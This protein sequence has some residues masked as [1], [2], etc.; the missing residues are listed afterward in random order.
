MIVNY[1]PTPT[2]EK[3]MQSDAKMRVLAGPIG[4]LAPNT[5]IVTEEGP[6]PIGSINRPVRVLS[7]NDSTDQFQLSQASAAFP[8][9]TDYLYRVLTTEG[10]FVA[11][12]HHLL[13]TSGRIWRKVEELYWD[14]NHSAPLPTLLAD[15]QD[16]V[17]TMSVLREPSPQDAPRWTGKFSGWL[18]RCAGKG[19]LYD[20]PLREVLGSD[21]LT[22]PE[23]GGAQVS[24]SRSPARNVYARRDGRLA[25][26][27]Q[28]IRLSIF[29]YL[30]SIGYFVRHVL[31]PHAISACCVSPLIG[32]HIVKTAPLS[33]RS[34]RKSFLRQLVGKFVSRFRSHPCSSTERAIISITREKV[35]SEYWDIQVADTNN[36][37]T[38]DGTVHHN[39]GKSVTCCFEVIRRASL[40]KADEDGIRRSRCAVVRNTMKQLQDTTIKTFM[41]WFPEGRFGDFV[42]TTKNYNMKWGDV[43]CEV[44]FRALDTPDDKRNLLSLELTF[45]WF[46]ECRDIHEEI[47]HAMSGRIGRYPSKRTGGPSWFGMWGDTNMPNWGSWWQC[48]MEHLDPED[49][50]SPNDNGWDVFLQPSGRSPKGENLENLPDDYY[51]TQG[52][53]EDFIRVYIDGEYGRSLSGEPVWSKFNPQF[54]MATKSLAW[55]DGDALMRTMPRLVIG[56]DLGLTPAAVVG[57]IDPRGRLL[58]LAEAVGFDIGVQ[59]FVRTMLRP[60]LSRKFPGC[61]FVVSVDPAGR[62]RAQTDEKTAIQIIQREGLPAVSAPTNSLVARITAVDDFLM[63]QVEGDAALL[64]DPTCTKLKAAMMGGYRYKRNAQEVIEKNKHSHVAEALQYLALNLNSTGFGRVI[65]QRREVGRRSSKGWT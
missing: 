17:R 13:L 4:C 1:T 7:W 20:R 43:E 29:A 2:C 21:P 62:Q 44:M 54:H 5:L 30:L 27:L 18:G 11:A 15:S 8:K 25:R 23:Q 52:R 6:V 19:R 32:E 38:V 65:P 26:I 57:M 64:I 59:R 60:M 31:H 36:Y 16:P 12:G 47:I 22:S 24:V 45:A 63:R 9:G 55:N 51:S 40:Q 53:S 39:S 46:N 61:E 41:D 33:V 49:G 35:K 37:V 50:V 28:R 34:R 56:M 48:Q 14:Q 10:V 58:V 3:F 42:R